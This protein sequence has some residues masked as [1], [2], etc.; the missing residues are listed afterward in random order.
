[1]ELIYFNDY[2]NK[3]KYD[4]AVTIG[5]FDGIHLAHQQLI[6][7]TK[8]VSEKLNYKSAVITFDPHPSLLF[9]KDTHYLMTDF[10]TKKE[11]IS[12]LG[13]DFL[14]L[15]PFDL[16]FASIS[17]RL[18][19]NDYLIKLNVKEVIVGSDF[20]FGCKGSGNASSIPELSNHKINVEIVDLINYEGEKIGSTKIKSLLNNGE[21]EKANKLLGY[22][23]YFKGSVIKGNNVGKRIGFLT[24]NIK[25]DNIK[26]IL[27]PGV[28]GVLIYVDNVKYLGMMNIGHN[29]TCNF[30]DELST[31]V[32]IFDL[33]EKLY[34]KEVTICCL[35]FVRD[36]KKFNSVDEL[37]NQLKNDKEFIINKNHI[38]AI[39]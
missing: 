24:A 5:S 15:I 34:E 9:N 18:F 1:M 8:K 38:L 17:P 33:N 16:E 22:L 7:V 35:C 11:M 14:I 12:A 37:I 2:L 25:N 28:Y 27:K 32:N 21:V 3:Y 31:E 19:I 29:P 6:N 20:K 30:V 26:K 10:D 13:V 39:K 36:E 4:L 23:Y